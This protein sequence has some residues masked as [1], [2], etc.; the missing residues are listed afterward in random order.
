MSN[1]HSKFVGKDFKKRGFTVSLNQVRNPTTPEEFDANSR[2]L[3]SALKVLK[4]RMMNEGFIKEL[5]KREFH[6][7]KGQKRRKSR[8]DAIL[9]ER[10]RMTEDRREWDPSALVGMHINKRK[11]EKRN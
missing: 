11:K 3:E 10:N 9:R 5:R 6:V 8:Q 2:S 4:K 1:K 7:T